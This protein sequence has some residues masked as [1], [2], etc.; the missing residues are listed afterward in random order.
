[1]QDFLIGKSDQSSEDKV[2]EIEPELVVYS[3]NEA[4]I[5]VAA[6]SHYKGIQLIQRSRELLRSH[7]V[8]QGR[9]YRKNAKKNEKWIEANNWHNET[10]NKCTVLLAF[11]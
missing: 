10:T 4:F 11:T 2:F 9:L 6:S 3:W 1:M 8:L 7:G 5:K